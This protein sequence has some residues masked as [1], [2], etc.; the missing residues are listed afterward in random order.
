MKSHSVSS[1]SGFSLVELMVTV[2]IIGVLA[3]LAVPQYSKFSAKAKQSEAKAQLG[4]IYTV[5]K[6]FFVE[7][8]SFSTCLAGI[9]YSPEGAQ[10]RYLVGF[11]EKGT[12]S[13]GTLTC[14]VL[15]LAE[16]VTHWQNVQG[17]VLTAFDALSGFPAATAITAGAT[18]FQAAAQ[19]IVG[20]RKVQGAD[21]RD[22]WTIDQN[23]TLT[24]RVSGI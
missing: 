6:A 5:E 11:A 7:A 24:N 8:N 23:Q 17:T 14:S 21:V 15:D 3:T 19:G 13:A 10:R 2:G 22:G 4:S 9:G 12:M 1:V 18:T 20:T 16:G